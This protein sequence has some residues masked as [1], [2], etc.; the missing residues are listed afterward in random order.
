MTTGSGKGARSIGGP[1]ETDAYQGPDTRE[2]WL[3]TYGS[4]EW[5]RRV[6]SVSAF[7]HGGDV[8]SHKSFTNILYNSLVKAV[9]L[10]R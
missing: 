6:G 4:K 7:L 9:P 8:T 3:V 1:I 5:R 10:L 2:I